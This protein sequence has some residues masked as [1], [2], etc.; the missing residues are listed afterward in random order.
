[1]FDIILID[2]SWIYNK[3]YYVAKTRPIIEGHG[4]KENQVQ[5][6]DMLMRLFSLIE[7]SHPS[8]K[9]LLVLD[10]P[11][12]TTT[13]FTLYKEYKQNRNK[14]EKEEVYKS[15]KTIVGKLS[16]ELNKKFTFVRAL[17]YEADQVIA[18]LAEKYQ[19]RYQVLIFTGD[20]D[21]LQLSYYSNISISDKYE[22][23]MFLTKSDAE[24]FGKFKNSKGEDFT[25]ISNNKRDILKYRVLKGDPSD[26]LSPVF[27]RIKDTEI[28]SIIKNYWI[29][30]EELTEPRINDILDDLRS[31]DIKLA[32]KLE[33]NKDIW[34][35]NYKVMNLYGLKDLP[36]KKVVKHG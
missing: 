24:I 20:K 16:Q 19:E 5:V 8:S 36:V 3:Y 25:R 29:D 30:E 12:S 35:R 33:S 4:Q 11:L 1:M 9:V 32:Q 21:L 15:F 27:P 22:K 18:S 31:D 13:N 2:F 17:G 7:R 10:S 6:Y 14:K 26:N 34:L 28:V 23:G